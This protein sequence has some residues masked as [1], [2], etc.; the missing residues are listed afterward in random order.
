VIVDLGDGVSAS[1]PLAVYTDDNGT[2][3]RAT[4][5]AP[6]AGKPP[7][8]AP[9]GNDRATRL[10]NVILAWN[11]FQ[12][13]YPYFDVVKTDWPAELKKGLERAATDANETA[14]QDS[15]RRLVAALQ[16]GHGHVANRNLNR[17]GGAFPPVRWD[18]I[19][20]QLVITD[21]EKK[22]RDK[23]QPGDVVVSVNDVPTAR[24]LAKIEELQSGATPQFIRHNAL[25]QL[26]GGPHLS[27]LKLELQRGTEKHNVEVSRW[28]D[29]ATYFFDRDTKSPKKIAEVRPGIWYVDL[30]RIT[31]AN[32]AEAVPQ[33]EK[34]T[35]I[36]F[37][38]RG[39]PSSIS[40]NPIGHITDETITCA[41]WHIP[42]V[43]YPDRKNMQ[44]SFS[45]WKVPPRKPRF[46]AKVAFITDGRAISY[47]ETYLGIIEHYKLAEI[48]GGPTAGTNGN[49]N[50]FTL[51][52][53]YHISWTGM[54]VLKHDGKQHHGIGIQPTVPAQRTI[55]GVKEG[56]D[57][58]LEKAIRVV[59]GK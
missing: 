11:V 7:T 46:T 54:K 29:L 52:G 5:S 20:N 17:A 21:V 58:L 49:V 47:A 39:Y 12:H 38:L 48:V 10:A 42:L 16:D 32:F 30:D 41:Q 57:E 4:A 24:A 50:P 55:A 33:L 45:N 25:T 35:G 8:F 36:I 6:P 3:P 40:T 15:L 28:H 23:I 1:I 14:F 31:D 9:S 27:S 26:A 53:G 44:F 2:L 13:F 34:A 56:K 37:D 51:P 19:E 59:G 18:W 22:H 43:L